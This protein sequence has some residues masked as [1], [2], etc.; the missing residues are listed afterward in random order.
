MKPHIVCLISLLFSSAGTFAQEDPFSQGGL[1]FS[2][3]FFFPGNLQTPDDFVNFESAQV[4]P[5]DLS[6][7]G[8][9]LAACN[10]PDGSIEL[11]SIAP[12]GQPSHSFTLGVGVDPVSVRFRTNDELWVVNQI[13]D[14]V[15][16]VSVKKKLI[17]RTI[18][19]DDM[20]ADVL[21]A[22]G[23]AFVS[24]SKE[25]RI[26]VYQLDDLDLAPTTIT[27][28]G[29]EPRSLALS[30]DGST[31]Y[32]A[33]FESGNRSTI[34]GGGTDDLNMLD[35]PPTN[36]ISDPR[37]PYE[38]V[39]PPPNEGTAIQPAP[40]LLQENGPAVSLIVKQDERGQ[41][42]DDNEGDWSRFVD[43]DLANLS[44]RPEGWQ[45]I[46]HDV[47]MIDTETLDVTYAGGLMNICMSLAVNPVSGQVS[48]IGTDGKNEIRYEPNLKSTF[49][50]VNI[51]LVSP[52]TEEPARV[53]NLNPHL[54]DAALGED[55]RVFTARERSQALGDPRSIQ[56]TSDGSAAFVTGRGSNN[57]V[58][59]NANGQRDGS[60][61][62][63]S[64]GEGPTGLALSSN[65][66][67]LYVLNRY[68]ASLSVIDVAT[69]HETSRLS[70]YDPTPEM[71]KIGRRHFTDTHAT[72]GLGQASCA[73]CHVDART[74]RL[75]WDLG[76]PTAKVIPVKT[77]ILFKDGQPEHHPMKG[78]MVTQT[79]QGM[80][81]SGP[82]HW[83]GDKETF[84]EFN[85]T[86]VHLLGREN[87]L[88][89]E[90]FDELE[91]Y[92]ATI[93]FPPN[94]YRKLN[95]SLPESLPLPGHFTTG[96]FSEAGQPLPDGRPEKGLEL[97]RHRK[98]AMLENQ[99]CQ[100]CHQQTSGL[101]EF[102][103][104]GFSRSLG[105]R[106][107]DFNNPPNPGHTL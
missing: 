40:R 70:L 32:A 79:F 59:L 17:Q 90:E 26:L 88:T 3:N 13:S 16:L 2:P 74:D 11:F 8:K 57:V 92:L 42:M 80:V 14:T 36:V 29:E 47:A 60:L 56:W 83:R 104:F 89:R 66:Q 94:P 27:I 30:P 97:F 58:R 100:D 93:T 76:D 48:V 7:D 71:I 51:G 37:G 78:P 85:P 72:S 55:E 22:N 1:F 44:G 73:S 102:V 63:I 64:V 46:D 62:P 98:H 82:F 4:H 91:R 31:L 96:R 43:G 81:G 68:G 52:G 84:A 39:N 49:H 33:I 18:A 54:T 10:T 41:W 6:P 35:Y 87:E 34:I 50:S 95:N 67:T 38:G 21:F 19:T 105:L 5:L 69:S 45:L 77:A 20:P 53:G 75:A 106:D 25:N 24:C 65:D 103:A 12:D 99:T 107:Q 9:T 101:G 86:F 15:N 28:E 23:R 61:D